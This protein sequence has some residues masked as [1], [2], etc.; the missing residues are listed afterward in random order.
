MDRAEQIKAH[1]SQMKEGNC[2]R[3]PG[4]KDFSFLCTLLGTL[5][6]FYVLEWCISRFLTVLSTKKL[7]HYVLQSCP[8]LQL[9]LCVICVIWRTTH[10][11]SNIN[12]KSAT[13]NRN[14][15]T[16]LPFCI[17]GPEKLVNV[18]VIYQ[19]IICMLHGAKRYIHLCFE[20][21]MLHS[22]YSV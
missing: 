3:H 14:S 5:L 12:H 17:V 6:N 9:V 1:V 21:E 13:T 8:C 22:W 20:I 19:Y 7:A 15:C 2:H 10:L 11:S 18:P 16:I 4:H